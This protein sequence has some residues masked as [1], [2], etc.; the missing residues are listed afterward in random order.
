MA[1]GCGG[2]GCS[3]LAPVCQ[4]L[5]GECH[6]R[7]GRLKAA[8]KHYREQLHLA[9]QTANVREQQRAH[10]NLGNICYQQAMA[11]TCV[12]HGARGLME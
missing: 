9:V 10:V 6:Q 4:R 1:G 5:L 7:Q 8:A 3:A 11:R 12:R 2:C